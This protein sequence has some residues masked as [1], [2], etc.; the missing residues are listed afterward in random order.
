[1]PGVRYAYAGSARVAR[2]SSPVDGL[3]DVG[4]RGAK[5]VPGGAVEKAASSV[6][7]GDV[8]AMDPPE[9]LSDEGAMIWRV[10]LPDLI[11]SKVFRV[12]D[13]ILLSELCESLGMAREF[14]GEIKLLQVEQTRAYTE[15][16][17]EVAEK[18]SANLKRARTGYRQMM[19][20]AM[21]ISGEFGISPV[22][23]LRLGLMAA[24][25]AKLSDFFAEDDD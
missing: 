8:V 24:T 15:K 25:N 2:P 1:M 10:L 13:A 11:A 12:S 9:D 6:P 21:S 4:V 23:R 16:D 7:S 18:I 14:R 19:Q 20:T 22:A 3:S 17:F 5:P